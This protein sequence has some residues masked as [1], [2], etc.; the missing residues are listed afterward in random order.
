MKAVATDF[1][2]PNGLCFSPDESLLYIADSGATHER[3][4]E[5]GEWKRT[6]KGKGRH[7]RVF[8]VVDGKALVGAV[9]T[10]HMP[11]DSAWVAWVASVLER[12]S[13]RSCVVC[14]QC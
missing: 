11:L 14:K 8:D 13:A 7:V 6:G 3:D 5:T 9:H 4:A 2:R 12:E 10:Y 1:E